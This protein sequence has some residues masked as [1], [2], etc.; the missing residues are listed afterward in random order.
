MSAED[1][2]DWVLIPA[3]WW[4]L[5]YKDIPWAYR[6]RQQWTSTGV[7]A[8]IHPRPPYHHDQLF[9]DKDQLQE[10]SE[11]V[12][13]LE[14]NQDL[15][16]VRAAFAVMRPYEVDVGMHGP[17]SKLCSDPF[18]Y[19]A[20]LNPPLFSGELDEIEL[21]MAQKRWDDQV[22]DLMGGTLTRAQYNPLDDD[23][24]VDRKLWNLNL[25][26]DVKFE[27]SAPEL[28][29][30]TDSELS[31]D[32]DPMPA[33][34]HGDKKSYAAVV[35][36]EQASQIHRER[37]VVAPSPSKPL[38]ASALDFIPGMPPPEST[39][40]PDSSESPYTSP[41]YEFHFPSLNAQQSGSRSGA[42]SLPPNL[43]KDEQGFYNE[44]S[45]SPSPVARSHAST[46]TATPRRQ[47]AVLLPAFLADSSTAPRNRKLKTREIVDRLRSSTANGE[48]SRKARITEPIVEPRTEVDEQPKLIESRSDKRADIDGWITSVCENEG[49]APE[50]II[51][52]DGWIEGIPT[53]KPRVVVKNKK[54][55][56]RSNSSVNSNFSMT[57]P[58]SSTSTISTFPS[59]ASSMTSF[60]LPV[61]PTSTTFSSPPF[62]PYPSPYA[63]CGNVFSGNQGSGTSSGSGAS[64]SP[65]AMAVANA[66]TVHD[67]GIPHVPRC[68]SVYALPAIPTDPDVR[69]WEDHWRFW[70][71]A[72]IVGG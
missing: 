13:D 33:T 25:A 52:K 9:V 60:G 58:S 67:A 70:D 43:R 54:G 61:T 39:P 11:G 72:C 31:T 7:R 1:Q 55:H 35:F 17:L 23:D 27:S 57:P 45:I 4:K 3:D 5:S 10:G 44:I 42:R 2:D 34:P 29:D 69:E 26:E 40:S 20:R 37:T 64:S 49:K 56:K 32:S 14:L 22:R 50:A 48:A 12:G 18:P 24:E 21:A 68:Q 19:V 6:R 36:D 71:S 28:V 62:Y 41:T 46:R 38:N 30:L 59:P 16:G 66:G 63:S 53:A 8:A 15:M 47:S 51:G 65:G